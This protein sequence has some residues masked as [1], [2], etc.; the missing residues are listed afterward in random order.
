[1]PFKDSSEGQTQY[2][3]E[4][5]ELVGEIKSHQD[6][7]APSTSPKLCWLD[8]VAR[9]KALEKFRPFNSYKTDNESDAIKIKRLLG[10]I[11]FVINNEKITHVAQALAFAQAQIASLHLED[12]SIEEVAERQKQLIIAFHEA[13]LAAKFLNKEKTINDIKYS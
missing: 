11:N 5:G 10:Q 8:K 13:D 2:L 4:N 1:M 12:N 3:D 6:S 7:S 9:D